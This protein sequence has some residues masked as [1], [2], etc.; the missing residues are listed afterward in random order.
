MDLDRTL[1]ERRIDR[2]LAPWAGGGPGV[3][4]G[5]AMDGRLAAHRHAGRAS[6]EH[7]VPIGPATR[8]RIASVSKQFTCAAILMLAHDG[9][10]DV[11]DDARTHLPELPD[12]GHTITLAHLMHN[13]SGIRDMLEIMRQGGADLGTP[14]T[15]ADLLAG[16][17]RQTTL[18][19][20][21]GSRFLY[22]NSNFL[23]LGLVAE[24]ASGQALPDF[25]ESRIFGPLGMNATR[26][27]PDVFAAVPDLATGYVPAGAGWS[28]AP[29]S[30][31][32]HGEG[33]LVSTVQD[34][35]LW[36]RNLDTGRVGG[37]WLASALATQAPFTNGTGNRYARGQAVRDYR[38]HAT[39]SHGGLWPGYRT[40][41]LRVPGLATVIA[42]ANNGTIDPNL[43]AHQT[44]DV[45]LDMRPGTHPAPRRPD[46]AGAQPLIGRWIDPA[47]IATLDIALNAE[48]QPTLTT[49]GQ[50]VAAEALPG[51]GL[52]APRAMAVLAV[53]GA[54]AD[55]I[56]VE[57][58]AGTVAT[59]RR[60]QAAPTLPE[61]LA[62]R[63][64][65]P[66]MAATWT[67]TV[68]AGAASVQ[69]SGPVVTGPQWP[70]DP[71]D[72]DAVR[73]HFP[74]LLYRAWFDVRLLRDA[75]GAVTGLEVHGGRAKAVRF[76]RL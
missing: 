19:F 36:D 60:T 27:T 37:E 57:Q 66:E 59:W 32:L 23:L 35:A 42:I 68:T 28:R 50:A 76:A 7:A 8:F 26:L 61:G 48:G 31:P 69:A 5:V 16:I 63:Y 62:G 40:E 25:L 10:L 56:E 64:G 9:L 51:G 2:L 24:R 47:G 30:F 52:V 72:T 55:A 18:N 71:I 38:G 67:V 17:C 74:G 75:S 65:S 54:G 70:V 53:R 6:V 3:T 34:L 11:Q 39:I 43:L 20:T 46:P 22:S 33:G 14:V 12:F 1:L 41:F 4:I 58:D 21:P 45:L 13:T 49:N 44:L 15:Q 73:V 29:H